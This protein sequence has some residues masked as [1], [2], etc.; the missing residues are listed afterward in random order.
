MGGGGD[1]KLRL[2]VYCSLKKGGGDKGPEG[3]ERR[4]LDKRLR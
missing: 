1:W 2:G 3:W 4:D